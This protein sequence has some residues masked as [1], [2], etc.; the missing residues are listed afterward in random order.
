[1][2]R[3]SVMFCS[4]L[5]LLAALTA[6]VSAQPPWRPEPGAG[7]PNPVAFLKQALEQAGATA[8]SADQEKQIQTLV[9]SI[10][11]TQD[12]KQPNADLQ[13]ALSTYRDAVLSGNLNAAKSA[14]GTL[15]DKE[16]A[17]S[18]AR[19]EEQAG[20]IIQILAILTPD[21]LNKLVAKFDTNGTFGIL[22][23]LTGPGMFGRGFHG[24]PGGEGP[25]RGRAPRG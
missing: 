5:F 4:W 12:A 10:R 3:R 14:A 8:L 15:A 13:G 22:Q 11:Q 23:R 17:A 19:L 24:G 9:D 25:M 6:S 7:A 1:M 2:S 16:A 18:Q 21:Q 20:W